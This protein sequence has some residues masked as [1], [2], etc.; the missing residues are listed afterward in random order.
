MGIRLA[1]LMLFLDAKMPQTS[2]LY[3]ATVLR[4]QDAKKDTTFIV[5]ANSNIHERL[6]WM[7]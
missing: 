7:A 5:S 2:S 6:L 4:H 3:E 1:P